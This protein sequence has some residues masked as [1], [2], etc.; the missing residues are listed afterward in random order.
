MLEL[1]PVQLSLDAA[2]RAAAICQL[3]QSVQQHDQGA[4]GTS[5]NTDMCQ[6]YAWPVAGAGSGSTAYRSE[7]LLQLSAEAAREEDTVKG[8]DRFHNALAL[9]EKYNS[10]TWELHFQYLHSLMLHWQ[11]ASSAILPL[12]KD[13]L[14][15]LMQHPHGTVRGILV[16]TWP[17][18]QGQRQ[19]HVAFALKLLE[20]CFQWVQQTSSSP[21][22]APGPALDA[23]PALLDLEGSMKRLVLLQVALHISV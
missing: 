4:S 2:Y 18:L 10:P 14:P 1:A 9:A 7:Q 13:L 20:K 16:Q 22:A 8:Q 21:N 15:P 11:H 5:A 6:D 19:L 17:E 23:E 3:R 12:V